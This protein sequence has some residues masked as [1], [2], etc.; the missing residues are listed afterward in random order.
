MTIMARR[1]SVALIGVSLLAI[2]LPAA[3]D[4]LDITTPYGNKDGC[5][6]AKSGQMDSDDTLLLK[7]D[8]FMSYGTA[9]EF[10]QV[11][12]GKDGKV[13]VG[14]CAFEGEDGFGTQNFVIRKSQKDP[15][16]LTIYASNG[17]VFGEVSPCK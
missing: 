11:L 13:V 5:K 2:A 14:L 7:A 8:G 16:A 12:T 10:V 1:W 4:T 6:Y 15:A 3:A 9:C 17:E